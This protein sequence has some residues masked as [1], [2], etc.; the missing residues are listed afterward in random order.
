[1]DVS[2]SEALLLELLGR[3]EVGGEGAV[4]FADEVSFEAPHDQLLGASFGESA[5]HV[6]L[7]WRVPAQSADDDHVERPVGVAV[8]VAVEAVV[9]LPARRG[10]YR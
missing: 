6:C 10:V 4:D 7:C 3:G 2:G 9:S 1:L 8:A 5:G